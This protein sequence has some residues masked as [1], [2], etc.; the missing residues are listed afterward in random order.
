MDATVYFA[1]STEGQQD[2]LRRGLPAQAH[3]T[4][5]TNIEVK[6]LRIA[7]ILKDGTIHI[8]AY[9]VSDP[10]KEAPC[11]RLPFILMM[12]KVPGSPRQLL[13][14]IHHE[15]EA[16]QSFLQQPIFEGIFRMDESNAPAKVRCAP[17]I[18]AL[19]APYRKFFNMFDRALSNVRAR[20]S[21]VNGEWDV[22]PEEGIVDRL[23]NK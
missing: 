18:A 11:G 8:S 22:A 15:L 9:S 3:Q 17:M 16:Q 7:T 12:N 13:D 5:V 21:T 4:V 14:S 10:S 23:W 6:D 20:A 2:A 19:T 1:L